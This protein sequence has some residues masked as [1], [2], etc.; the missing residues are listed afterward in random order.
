[1]LLGVGKKAP[2]SPRWHCSFFLWGEASGIQNRQPAAPALS[3]PA[4]R[5]QKVDAEQPP[6]D[7]KPQL[8]AVVAELP[9]KEEPRQRKRR[10][11]MMHSDSLHRGSV[12]VRVIWGDTRTSAP[13][14]TGQVIPWGSPDLYIDERTFTTGPDGT[15]QVEHLSSRAARA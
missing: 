13:G 1:V 9:K 10:P 8:R 5:P 15:A 7:S 2:C 14:V 4:A 12:L 3:A 11:S 6:P